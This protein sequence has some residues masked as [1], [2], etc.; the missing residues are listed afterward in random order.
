MNSRK[1]LSVGMT[2]LLSGALMAG[3]GGRISSPIAPPLDDGAI[4]TPTVSGVTIIFSPSPIVDPGTPSNTPTPPVSFTN[5][6]TNTQTTVLTSTPTATP[7]TTYTP[8]K[9]FTPSIDPTPVFDTATFTPTGT[10]TPACA[11]MT[12]LAPNYIVP[13]ESVSITNDSINYVQVYSSWTGT[14]MSLNF[15]AYN[16]LGPTNV[17]MGLYSDNGGQP[18]VLLDSTNIVSTVVGWNSVPL[19]TPYTLGSKTTYWIGLYS[20]STNFVGVG[21]T[22]GS[23]LMQGGT[24]L[25]SSY[26]GGAFPQPGS[27]SFYGWECP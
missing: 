25:P 8:T 6:F 19:I 7:T 5:T 21:S 1:L 10:T 27:P 11:G 23:F 26:S 15:Y 12:C 22:S 3:C 14:L 20:Q 9:T 16:L 17:S 2:I 24:S 13:G 18:G 4:P